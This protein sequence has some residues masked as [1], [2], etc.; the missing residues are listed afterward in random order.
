VG[1]RELP[2]NGLIMLNRLTSMSIVTSVRH[3][4]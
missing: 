2:E 4:A 1:I 3:A